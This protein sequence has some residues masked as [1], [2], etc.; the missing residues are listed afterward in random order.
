M[1]A[2]CCFALILSGFVGLQSAT[3]PAKADD[4][5]KDTVAKD[6]LKSHSI[7]YVESRATMDRSAADVGDIV[8]KFTVLLACESK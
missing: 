2:I 1:K 8:R 6:F 7:P 3:G 5:Y 4:F